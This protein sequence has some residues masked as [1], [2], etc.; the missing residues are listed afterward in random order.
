MIRTSRKVS[1][2][3]ARRL[4][5]LLVAVVVAADQI[6]KQLT[7]SRIAKGE[8]VSLFLGIDLVHTVNTGIA[9][10]RGVGRGGLIIPILLVI[11]VVSFLASRELRGSQQVAVTTIV[12]YALI[13]GGAFGNVLDRLAR[14]PGWGR[15]AVIDMVDVGWWPVFNLADSA[16]CVGVAV[17]LVSSLFVDRSPSIKD[18]AQLKEEQL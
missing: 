11:G 5:A 12:G 2:L 9:F 13:L 15:G 7:V 14:S 17:M 3:Q 8:R 1:T 4:S 16:L 18:A 10:S 6:T